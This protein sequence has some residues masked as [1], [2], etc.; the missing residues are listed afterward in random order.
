MKLDRELIQISSDDTKRAF[1]LGY[2]STH[3]WLGYVFEDV[4]FVK[5]FSVYRD[6]EYPDH[7]CNAEVYTTNRM[8]ELESLG[9]LVDLKPEEELVH[10]ETWEVYKTNDIPGELFGGR[11]LAEVLK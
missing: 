2:F 4:F 10:A 6:E 1:K 5:H 7:G 8:I 11:T 9:S 3:G